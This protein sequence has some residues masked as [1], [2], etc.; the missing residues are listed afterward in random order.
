LYPAPLSQSSSTPD[1]DDSILKGD[2][3]KSTDTTR[4]L[5]HN[6]RGIKQGDDDPD[7]EI[8]SH[9]Q[10]L[11]EVDFQAIPE[12]QLD[13]QKLTV[14]NQLQ[15]SLRSDFPGQ[16]TL[17]IDSS[18][19]DAPHTYKAGGTALLAI[20]NIVGRL[21]PKGKSGDALGRWS[22]MHL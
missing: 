9:D 8:L 19:S 5:F 22:I 13:T 10:Q 3:T 16:A 4:F 21:E 18:P 6:V 17:Q 7:L 15:S 14:R 2:F 1:P 12:H 20:G 11:L